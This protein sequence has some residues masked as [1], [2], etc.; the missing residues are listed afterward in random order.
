MVGIYGRIFG[1]REAFSPEAYSLLVGLAS[2]DY[3]WG[4]VY[5]EA[6]PETTKGCR[7]FFWA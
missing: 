1:V 5:P 3:L 2:A 6:Q 4:V 7:V